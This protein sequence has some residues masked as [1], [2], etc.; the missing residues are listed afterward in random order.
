MSFLDF[1]KRKSQY[2]LPL[3]LG[4]SSLVVSLRIKPRNRKN[5]PVP[6]KRKGFPSKNQELAIP[7]GVS[8]NQ[9]EIHPRKKTPGN[10]SW[11]GKNRGG[12]QG[13]VCLSCVCSA[14][15]GIGELLREP[16]LSLPSQPPLVIVKQ[17]W[18]GQNLVK[19]RKIF[20]V[21]EKS[22]RMVSNLV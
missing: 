11:R 5:R 2:L 4:V 17:N 12:C 16:L 14:H 15:H 10:S 21:N 1:A 9:R 6:A 20:Q 18:A 3:S 13:R 7:E 22:P 8:Q 19:K